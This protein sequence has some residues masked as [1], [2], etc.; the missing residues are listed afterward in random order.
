MK[1]KKKKFRSCCNLFSG[2]IRL[3]PIHL[4]AAKER[5]G[6][7]WFTQERILVRIFERLPWY[8][9]VNL[10]GIDGLTLEEKDLPVPQNL[11]M[12]KA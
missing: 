12:S 9:L 10:F 8:D 3:I 7:G 11:G 5:P 6:I 4:I 1:W 2:I